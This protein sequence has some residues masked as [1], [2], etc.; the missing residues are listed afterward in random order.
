MALAFCSEDKVLEGFEIIKNAK[1]EIVACD[2]ILKYFINTWITGSFPL[3]M[4]N[5][6]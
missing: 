6:H 3:C 2:K 1:P 5:H 4:W